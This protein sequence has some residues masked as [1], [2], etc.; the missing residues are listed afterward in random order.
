MSIPRSRSQ[1]PVV[2]VELERLP[3]SPTPPLR[4][5]CEECHKSTNGM[6]VSFHWVVFTFNMLKL[7]SLESFD[8]VLSS[9]LVSE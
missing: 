2:D 7:D 5:V 8:S 6:L 4:A 9:D 3:S 1:S